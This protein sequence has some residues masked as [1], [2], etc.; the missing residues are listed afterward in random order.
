MNMTQ[1]LFRYY[2]IERGHHAL[3]HKASRIPTAEDYAAMG[4]S[5]RERMADR[6]ARAAAEE[7]PHIMDGEEIVFMRTVTDLPDILTKEE[8]AEM[9][10]RTHIHELGYVSNI[11]VEFGEL[12]K[13]GLAS[14]YD[15]ADACQKKEIDALLEL[16]ERYRAEAEKQGRAELAAVL[17]RVP[18]Y[19]ARSLREALQSFR[20]LHYALWLEGEY[21]NNVGRFDRLMQPYFDRDR[22]AGMSRKEALAL[23]IDF[24]L[25][26]NKD[27]DLY[28]GVQQGDNGQSMVL[29]GKD[30]EGRDVY[31]A[32]SELCLE[33][34]RE[35]KLIDPKINLRVSKDTPFSLYE[36]GTELTECG[37]GFPQ[38]S[39]DD[40][41]IPGLIRLGYAPADAANY[42]MAACWEP[43]IQGV[44]DDI[45]NIAALN[46]PMLCDR[47]IRAHLASGG[48][49]EE[50]LSDVRAILREE[51]VK[52]NDSIGSVEFIP[53]PFQDLFRPDRRYHN[54][55]VHGSGMYGAVD[56][57]AAVYHYVY[58]E[59]TVGRADLLAAL[60]RNF[61]GYESLCHRLRYEAPKLGQDE[62]LTNR[63]LG[64]IL[65]AMVDACQGLKNCFGGV[66]RPGTGTAMYYLRHPEEHGATADGR[67][68][69]EAYGANFSPSLSAR[70][71]GPL[72]LIRSATSH[73]LTNN[74]NGGPLTLEFFRDIFGREGGIAKIAALVR[75][76]IVRGG[77]QLQLNTVDAEAMREAQKHPERYSR[78]VVR[79]W[80]WSAYFVELDE[81]F[82]N[83]VMA[84]QTYR[85]A[86]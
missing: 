64:F 73:D 42:V 32:L 6:F 15:T 19:G 5:Y 31:S 10:A 65:E 16:T 41:I 26:F 70:I 29:G 80:G 85:D 50:L 17:A 75:Y 2:I 21:H 27:S 53:A 35:L 11:C 37:L 72:S 86:N 9:G 23:I 39:N 47:A 81:E 84:R 76:Y 34:S 77:H 62:E 82:Q 69:G 46:L 14:V 33:A 30:E 56:A 4:L 22:A 71:P 1:E 57:L 40:V 43:T 13:N 3:R 78:L 20:I 28:V 79:I 24:F 58:D 18:R 74:I 7:V 67:R 12:I 83:H 25:S 59:G 60:D 61:V 49:F 55:G 44:G 45:P 36:K 48:S 66:W 63:L 54:F 68:A 8:W 52:I 38:Y 51:M